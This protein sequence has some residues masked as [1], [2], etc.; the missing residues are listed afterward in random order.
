[1]LLDRLSIVQSPYLNLNLVGWEKVVLLPKVQLYLQSLMCWL[2]VQQHKQSYVV[3]KMQKEAHIDER[4]TAYHPRVGSSPP[5]HV[6]NA[7]IHEAKNVF[8]RAW[9]M[10]YEHA[11]LEHR[12]RSLCSAYDPERLICVASNNLLSSS[13]VV[14]YHPKHPSH[15]LS[16][17]D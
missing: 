8:P 9:S 7:T 11:G 6:D 13:D 2:W 15:R 4:V 3:P 1:M 17:Y 16:T 10:T 12:R 5:C 14:L